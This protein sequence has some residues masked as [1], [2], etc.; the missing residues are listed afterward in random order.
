MWWRSHSEREGFSPR[1][2]PRA[3]ALGLQVVC[4]CVL[5]AP[6]SL[7]QAP[8]QHRAT[9][10]PFAWSADRRLTWADFQ[11]TPDTSRTAVAMTAYAISLNTACQGDILVSRV[12]STFL[13]QASWVKSAYIVNRRAETTLRHEQ[14]H[15]DLSEVLA[16]RLR[17]ELRELR[18]PCGAK[19]DT[20][21][22]LY[23]RYQKEDADTQ[24]RYDRET[25]HGTDLGPQKVWESRIQSW[26]KN[27]PE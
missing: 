7:A 3:K 17:A 6:T 23:A 11:G 25:G 1:V 21:A 2:V 27:L 9:V 14:G 5:L 10:E 24:R 19:D 26:L 15:F 13:P 18:S 4:A 20:R 22:A 12:T 16:R 8:A